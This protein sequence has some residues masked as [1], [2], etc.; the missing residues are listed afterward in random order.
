MATEKTFDK[1]DLLRFFVSGDEAMVGK[2]TVITPSRTLFG[3]TDTMRYPIA[4]KTEAL[5]CEKYRLALLVQ[6]VDFPDGGRTH[7]PKNHPLRQDP[8]VQVKYGGNSAQLVR[9]AVGD[10]DGR[11]VA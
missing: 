3:E 2:I 1:A 9:W 7:L 6:S 4:A 5:W 8:T 11:H 10:G